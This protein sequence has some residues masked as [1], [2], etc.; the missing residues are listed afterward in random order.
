MVA[1]QQ[2]VEELGNLDQEQIQIG[3][4]LAQVSTSDPDV[5]TLKA[6]LAAVQ[7]CL[8]LNKLLLS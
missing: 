8:I 5:A 7:V 4:A 6:S 1:E 3:T 2:M